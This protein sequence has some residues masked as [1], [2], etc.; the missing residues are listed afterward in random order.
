MDNRHWDNDRHDDHHDDHDYRG[1]SNTMRDHQQPIT[2]ARLIIIR[3]TGRG[4]TCIMRATPIP[5]IIARPITRSVRIPSCRMTRMSK[6]RCTQRP[7]T[8]TIVG[9]LPAA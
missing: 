4:T 2:I 7:I 9:E 5:I 6:L 1:H 8:G 3:I